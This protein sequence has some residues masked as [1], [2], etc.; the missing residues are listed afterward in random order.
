MLPLPTGPRV[1]TIANGT[2][3]HG[4]VAPWS[5]FQ[6]VAVRGV[7]IIKVQQLHK[8]Q[9][10]LPRLSAKEVPDHNAVPVADGLVG[11]FLVGRVTGREAVPAEQW[12]GCQE[13]VLWGLEL[14]QPT[15]NYL[16]RAC[17]QEDYEV[18]ECRIFLI[19]EVKIRD[20]L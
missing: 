3:A 17:S 15:D 12:N 14:L 2:D 13:A 16:H 7:Q 9:H 5:V 20:W 1:F 4:S 6:G 19:S 18:Q 11:G 10:L 8:F